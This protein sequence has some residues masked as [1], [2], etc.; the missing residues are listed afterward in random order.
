ML[1]HLQCC[2]DFESCVSVVSDRAEHTQRRTYYC[3]DRREAEASLKTCEDLGTFGSLLLKAH[4]ITRSMV[5]TKP[6][7]KGSE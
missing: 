1:L 7:R 4:R 5:P 2:S 6:E 3:I